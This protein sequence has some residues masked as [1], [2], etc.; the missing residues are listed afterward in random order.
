V[1]AAR[2]L[3]RPPACADGG[4]NAN[5]N[6]N[7]NAGGSPS[8]AGR[9]SY[10]FDDSAS[11]EGAGAGADEDEDEHEHE[12]E[13]EDD[14]DGSPVVEDDKDEHRNADTCMPQEEDRT[15]DAQSLP[16]Q[17]ERQQ[18]HERRWSSPGHDE[19]GTT[20]MS[21]DSNLA[22]RLLAM[23]QARQLQQQQQQQQQGW[24][25]PAEATQE[26]SQVT[27]SPPPDSDPPT[28]RTT[29]RPS[30]TVPPQPQPTDE[31]LALSLLAKERKQLQRRRAQAKADEQMAREVQTQLDRQSF[32]ESITSSVGDDEDML[33]RK[34]ERRRSIEADA[35]VATLL[36][37]ME[38]TNVELMQRQRRRQEEND[39]ALA[40]AEQ[41][42][43]RCRQK[44][45]LPSVGEEGANAESTT[46]AL[47]SEQQIQLDELLART[48]LAR[49]EVRLDLRDRALQHDEEV[50]RAEQARE[51][52]ARDVTDETMAQNLQEEH[53]R[54]HWQRGHHSIRT[55]PQEEV[56][57]V[58]DH[59]LPTSSTSPSTLQPPLPQIRQTSSPPNSQRLSP[60]A[61]SPQRATSISELENQLLLSGCT[62][63]DIATIEEV[64]R[65]RE[66]NIRCAVCMEP[67]VLGDRVRTLP[68]LHVFHSRCIDTWICSRGKC[69]LDQNPCL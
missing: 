54:D 52:A 28:P 50:A 65:I 48:E 4:G 7:G 23:H 3:R 55:R 45:G 1:V 61:L 47:S 16:P 30:S 68:C 49:D 26:Q 46:S 24:D 32:A 34:E 42:R 51:R 6:G 66:L 14:N 2:P 36:S 8:S 53:I 15:V 64:R 37:S 25:Q 12:S 56:G 18:Q 57:H 43:D 35:E 40:R 11:E 44:L 29:T 38:D 5:G 69:P 62:V 33:K 19:D 58:Q 59:P 27:V 10:G 60:A 9:F 41:E 39:E 31:Q 17:P 13:S 67:F 21:S 22:P 63:R 20:N